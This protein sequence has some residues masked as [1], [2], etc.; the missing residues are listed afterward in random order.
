MQWGQVAADRALQL[1]M[2]FSICLSAQ[3][4]GLVQPDVPAVHTHLSLQLLQ[5]R[6]HRARTCL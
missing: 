4:A 5:V 3:L 2:S 6:Q 1:S